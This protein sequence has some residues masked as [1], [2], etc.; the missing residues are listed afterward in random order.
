MTNS[1]EVVDDFRYRHRYRGCGL[2]ISENPMTPMAGTPG[3]V[4]VPPAIKFG[5]TIPLF[6]LRRTD[7]NVIVWFKGSRQQHLDAGERQHSRQYVRLPLRV[8]MG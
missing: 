2:Y 1:P 3:W 5:A 4:E 7:E 8:E 6:F